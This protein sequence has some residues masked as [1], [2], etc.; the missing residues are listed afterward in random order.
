MKICG[1]KRSMHQVARRMK[2]RKECGWKP[3]TKTTWEGGFLLMKYIYCPL[4]WSTH[5]AIC[6]DS[7]P[8]KG[9]KPYFPWWEKDCNGQYSRVRPTKNVVS[10]TRVLFFLLCRIPTRNIDNCVTQKFCVRLYLE[11]K[12]PFSRCLFLFF[13]ATLLLSTSH[14]FTF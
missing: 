3:H 11:S 5:H 4:I 12:S 14:S 8:N 7:V 6:E 10:G 9:F 13:F 2:T 1:W